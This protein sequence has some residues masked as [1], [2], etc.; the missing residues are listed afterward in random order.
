LNFKLIEPSIRLEKSFNNYISEWE[1][2]T[3]NIVPFAS[4]RN[5]LSYTEL[6]ENW[7]NNKTD[8]VYEKG[9]VPSTLYFLVDDTEKIYGALHF[10][11]ELNE[12]LL[13]TGGHIG[14]GIR[15]TLRQQGYATIMLSLALPIAKKFGLD[16][17]LITCDKNN[18]SSAKT[19]TKNGGVFEN[20]VFDNGEFTQ[21]Y[22]IDLF[23]IVV[24]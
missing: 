9:F 22:W 23:P 21:R 18:I 1:S 4:R 20:Q 13:R 6:L 5:G 7:K 2:T 15:P 3:E 10:R 24:Y 14:Y 12:F 8:K 16:K 11:H 19:I 17:V